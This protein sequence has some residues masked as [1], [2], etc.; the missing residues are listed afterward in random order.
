MTFSDMEYSGRKRVTQKEKFL[1]EMNEII[2]WADWVNKILPYYPAGKR[3]RPPRGIEVMLRM[4]LLQIWFNLSDEGLEDAIYDSYAMRNFVGINFLEEQ[5]P[6]A[7]TLLKFRH[8]LEEHNL[9]EAIFNDIK[10]RL[11]QAGLMMRGGTIVD[12][13]IIHSTPSTKNKEGTTPLQVLQPMSTIWRKPRS[14]FAQMMKSLM[15]IPV[16]SDFQNVQRS[17]LMKT[18]PRLSFGSTVDP[19]H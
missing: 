8:L 10:E 1:R 6:D 16:I 3:G 19:L 4:Y 5:V 15:V 9:G 13:T 17:W 14:S 18:S 7:T 12:A 2:P 11:Q